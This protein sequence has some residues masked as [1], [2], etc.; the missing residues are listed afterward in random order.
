M[1]SKKKVAKKK[2]AT[3]KSRARTPPFPAYP[4]WTTSKFFSFIRSAIRNKFTRWPPKYEVLNA[5]KSCVPKD[6]GGRQKFEYKC[7]ICEGKFA[8]KNV[9]V[10]HIIPCGSLKS[11]EDLSG[12]AE[13][14]FCSA[15][16]LRVVCKPCHKKVTAAER[17]KKK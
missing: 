10:D 17:A 5:A 1:T 6:R 11:F 8:Q 13:R 12:F 3:K 16:H 2:R 4:E 14:M 9:E 7:S 15:E